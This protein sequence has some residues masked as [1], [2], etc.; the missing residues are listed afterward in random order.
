[1]SFHER[2]TKS[3]VTLYLSFIL[4]I[5]YLGVGRHPAY[6]PP[7][8]SPFRRNVS[9]RATGESPTHAE[10]RINEVWHR[11]GLRADLRSRTGGHT[12]RTERPGPV[13]GDRAENVPEV[14]ELEGRALRESTEDHP[15]GEK[16]M[17]R[18]V[19]CR[20]K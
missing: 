14:S 12:G 9:F 19:L 1:M 8:D 13:R 15:E 16:I 7:P 17:K 20:R 2:F 3:T 4:R 11:Y 18:E 10:D 6:P 5:H